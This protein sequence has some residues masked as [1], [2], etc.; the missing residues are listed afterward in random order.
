[1]AIREWAMHAPAAAAPG[2]AR[3]IAHFVGQVLADEPKDVIRALEAMR[4]EHVQRSR[5]VPSAAGARRWPH[6]AHAPGA[7][8][9]HPSNAHRASGAH[10]R[11]SVCIHSMHDAHGCG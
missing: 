3:T 9:A 8:G 10:H 7:A 6:A 1:M 5:A 11:P 4:D 2:M